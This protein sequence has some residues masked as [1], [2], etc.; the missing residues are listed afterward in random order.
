[1]VIV[2][3]KYM[4][5]SDIYD[6]GIFLNFQAGSSIRQRAYSYQSVYC[7]SIYSA[8]FQGYTCQLLSYLL[9]ALARPSPGTTRGRLGAHLSNIEE[10]DKSSGHGKYLK[11][12]DG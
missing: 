6:E 9:A 3:L 11:K 7:A 12:P 2:I 8:L 5:T 1:M 4:R 10:R